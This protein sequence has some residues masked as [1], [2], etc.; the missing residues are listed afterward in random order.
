MDNKET[1]MVKRFY[2][3]NTDREW[4]RLLRD[5]FHQLE[6]EMSLRLLKKYLPKKGLILDA[7]G[8]PGR[9]TIELAKM[10]YEV[11]LLD[12]VAKNLEFAKTQIKKAKVEKQVKAIVQ[13]SITDL[14]QF[15]SNSFNAVIC[16]GGPLSHVHPKSQRQKAIS[17][18]IRVAKKVSPIFISVIGKYAV[19]LRTP[20]GWPQNVADKKYFA[21]LA[22]EGQDYRWV[23]NG[24]C[25]FFTLEEFEQLFKKRKV[26]IIKKVGLEGLNIE[27]IATTNFAKKYPKA[28]KNWLAIH[29]K[30]C[31]DPFVI[32]ASGHMMFIMKKV[33]KKAGK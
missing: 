6:L 2:T 24:F 31:S 23:K 26:K 30:M 12:L 17:E 9:Y 19:L 28:W 32:D 21:N 11:V 25:H 18:L 22:F 14:S 33:L 7:G 3:A 29:Q 4:G 1:K 8:G 5:P 13:G 10:G 20:S 15:K 16:L 27:P